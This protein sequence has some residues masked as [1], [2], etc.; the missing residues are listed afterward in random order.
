MKETPSNE[1]V[2]KSNEQRRQGCQSLVSLD[3][4]R[5]DCKHRCAGRFVSLTVFNSIIL[6]YI[7]WNLRLRREA[8]QEC[9]MG[10]GLWCINQFER[11]TLLNHHTA[12]E[13]ET[14][15]TTTAFGGEERN[16][17]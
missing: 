2:C 17:E 11:A 9:N 4:L 7:R 1:Q 12:A 6:G 15:A 14:D 5:K 13:G 10:T 16:K 3:S 8:E